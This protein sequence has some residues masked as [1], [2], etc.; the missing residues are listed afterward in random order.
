MSE[1]TLD[2]RVFGE[3]SP[4]FGCGPA[5]PF[6]LRLTFAREGDEVVTRTTP[7]ERY[8]GPPGIMHGGLVTTLADEV[9]AWALIGLRGKFGFTISMSTR[10][11]RAVRVGREVEGR[12]RIARDLGRLVDVDVRLVQDGEEALR[13]AFRFAVLDQSGAERLLGERLPE[14]WKRF[15]RLRERKRAAR[16]PGALRPPCAFAAG[17]S[18]SGGWGA[19]RR[20]PRGRGTLQS[21][22]GLATSLPRCPL[23]P[24]R[25]PVA[26]RAHDRAFERGRPGVLVVRCRRRAGE[27]PAATV[28]RVPELLQRD[29]ADA[30]ARRAPATAL[31]RSP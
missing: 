4:C 10:L 18:W 15:C 11:S 7:G 5:H 2:P 8:Q 9:A 25:A 12:A 14:A 1:P 16:I 29:G 26:V 27:R 30:K 20:A 28:T 13:G 21:S 22:A 3:E 24:G 23:R 31:P 6:G 17:S 19:R